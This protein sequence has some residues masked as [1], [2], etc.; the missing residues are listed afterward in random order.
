MAPPPST[1][2]YIA[3]P[4][5]DLIRVLLLFPSSDPT[6]E[7]QCDLT[8]ARLLDNIEGKN[9]YTTLSYV[10][11]EERD[12]HFVYIGAKTL[13]VGRNVDSALRHLRRRDLPI[14]LWVDA[15]CI[16]QSDMT[17]RN[18]QVRRMRAIYSAAQETI[19]YL[20]DE[21]GG[22]TCHSA[23]NFLE[24]HSQWAINENQDIDYTLPTAPE[25]ILQFR[26]DLED[27]EIDVLRRA[28]FRRVWVFQEVVV[29]RKKK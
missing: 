2:Q 23:W 10:W 6:S 21:D 4:E 20:G 16:N 15:I 5:P 29:S 19:I 7:V 27:V 18:H 28:W 11:G 24:R 25:N 3:L 12:S 13:T 1:Y 26:G 22:N 9:S 8:H 17:E 14:R